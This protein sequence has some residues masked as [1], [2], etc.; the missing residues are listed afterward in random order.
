[1]NDDEA[2]IWWREVVGVIGVVLWCKPQED[3]RKLHSEGTSA[4]SLLSG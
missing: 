1:M 3:S 2:L 4:P